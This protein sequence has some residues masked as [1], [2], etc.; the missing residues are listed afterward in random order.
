[1][2]SPFYS[3]SSLNPDQLDKGILSSLLGMVDDNNPYAKIYRM[4]KD[5]ISSGDN[6]NFHLKLITKRSMDGRTYKLPTASK[7]AALIVGDIGGPNEERDII[8]ERQNGILRRI[9][10][11][12]PLYLPLQ[13]PLL[14]P[15]GEDGYR[16]GISHR[17]G[18][19][20]T[21]GSSRKRVKLT[22]REWFAYRLMDRDVEPYT[23][24]RSGKLFQ[25]FVVDGWTMV[26][27]ERLSYIRNKQ[28]KLRAENYK[29]LRDSIIEGNTEC[30]TTGRCIILP[31]SF[32]GGDR[33]MS[34]LYHD[35]M[36]YTRP[37][38]SRICLSLLHANQNGQKL[39][40]CWQKKEF[41]LKI[42]RTLSIVSSK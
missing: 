20:G 3:T 4:T 10:E 30:S 24:L 14:F 17:E 37:M 27:S 31:S 2:R 36:I 35:A 38:A 15:Y 23:I 12:H 26:E 9:S 25:Q 5:R 40:D 39:P 18:D 29:S 32:Q 7:V 8:I 22:M 42:G 6:T 1:M 19:D 13:Y 34:E 16:L 28:T 11:L 33:F 21:D 41:V